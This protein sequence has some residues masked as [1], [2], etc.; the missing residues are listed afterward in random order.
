[1]INK[2]EVLQSIAELR[3]KGDYVYVLLNYVDTDFWITDLKTYFKGLYIDNLTDFD[4]DT[5]FLFSL[6]L[7]GNNFSCCSEDGMDYIRKIKNDY[8]FAI[9]I[10]AIAPYATYSFGRYYC[11]GNDQQIKLEQRD[12]AFLEEHKKYEDMIIEFFKE[13]NLQ[14]LKGE[15]LSEIVPGVTLEL[16]T[17]NVNVYNCLFEDEDD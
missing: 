10:C 14:L 3:N 13:H 16:K 12:H 15:I 17:K 2:K 9:R 7:C 11:E 4:Y 6:D 5:S 1:M 8:G